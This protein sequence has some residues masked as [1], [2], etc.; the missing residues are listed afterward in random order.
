MWTIFDVIRMF[1]PI[2]TVLFWIIYVVNIERSEFL[3]RKTLVSQQ[4][5]VKAEQ[6]CKV[7][8]TTTHF[9]NKSAVTL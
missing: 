7:S 8:F 1:K 6:Q 2:Q 4:C 5:F 3:F 9:F